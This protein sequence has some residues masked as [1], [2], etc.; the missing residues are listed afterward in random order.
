MSAK[1]FRVGVHAGINNFVNSFHASNCLKGNCVVSM[2][3]GNPGKYLNF[4]QAFSRTV[5]HNLM[6]V[7]F[8]F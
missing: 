6:K 2:G 1:Y 3:S 7:P 5:S 8:G 4:S